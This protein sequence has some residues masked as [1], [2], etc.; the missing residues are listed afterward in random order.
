MNLLIAYT[1]DDE[2]LFFSMLCASDEE[3][4]LATSMA[5]KWV[6]IDDLTDEQ[7][8][9]MENIDTHA[10]VEELDP[11]TVIDITAFNQLIS[12]GWF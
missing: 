5:G 1:N 3:Y 10:N 12:C 2:T 6:N 8:A 9:F 4:T 7:V 11:H